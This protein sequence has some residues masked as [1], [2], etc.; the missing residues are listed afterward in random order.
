MNNQKIK[1]PQEIIDQ[2]SVVKLDSIISDKSYKII[3]VRSPEGIDSQGSIPG[4]INIP[5]D[6]VESAFDPQHEDYNSMF[7]DKEAFLF[8]CTG[9][10]MSYMAAIKAQEKGIKN[11]CNLE[12]GHS[13]W[14]KFKTLNSH[15]AL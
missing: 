1:A 15:V 10:V 3:D 7:N 6:S 14:L 12:G 9:G 5:F 2:I 8:C 13:A 11:V 4:A